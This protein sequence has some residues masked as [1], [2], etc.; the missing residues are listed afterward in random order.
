[1]TSKDILNVRTTVLRFFQ[2][3]VFVMCLTCHG[4]NPAPRDYAIIPPAPT[5]SALMDNI[6]YDFVGNL[7]QTTET[8]E[9]MSEQ[10]VLDYHKAVTNISYDIQGRPVKTSIAIDDNPAV[11]ISVASY[12]V[13]GHLH[14]EEGAVNTTYQYDIRSNLVGISGTSLLFEVQ[15]FAYL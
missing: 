10:T 15:N 14:S 7:T 3:V 6:E 4:E 2:T 12:D 9:Q 13:L 8:V 5:V 11:D 1:M